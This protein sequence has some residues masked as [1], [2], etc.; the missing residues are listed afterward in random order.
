MRSNWILKMAGVVI[1]PALMAPA[2]WAQK[3]TGDWPL[4]RHDLGGTGYSPLKQINAENA[5]SLKQAW[6]F[7]LSERGGLEVTPIAVKGVMYLP[8]ANKVFA[9]DA[10]TGKEIWHYDVTQPSTRGVAYWPGDKTNPPRIIFTTFGRKMIALDAASGKIVPAFG[11]EGIVDMTVGYNG[12]PTIYKNIVLVGA[13]V[14]E[15]P[16]GPAGDSRAFDA[17]TG[18]QLWD[19][20][21]V[22]EPGETG[23]ETWL[24]DGWK[25]RSGTNVWG[26]YMTV[27][28]KTNTVFMPIGGP[29]P[30]YYGG[31]RP[32]DNLFGNSIVAVDADSGKLKW[33]FQTIHHDLWDQDLPPGP[34]FVDI[35]QNGKTIPALVA[36]GKTSLMFILNRDT[37]KPVFGVEERPVSKGD[38][39]GEWYSP[40]EPFPLKPP[41]LARMSYKP[42]DM[43]TAEYTTPEHVKACQDLL[44][45]SGGSF[46]NAGPFTGWP[47]HEDGTPPKTAI[48]FPGGTGGVNWGGVATDPASHYIYVQTHDMSLIG[49]L[50][51][52][53]PGLVYGR[54]NDG[55]PQLYDRGSVDGPGPYFSF[56]VNMKDAEGH[57]LGVWPCQKPPWGRL[58]AIDANTGDIAWQSVIGITEGLPE[59]KQNTGGGGSAGPIATAGG[60]IFIGA[61]PDDRFRAIDS[62]TG[63]QLWVTKLEKTANADP[64]TYEGKDGKQYVAIVAGDTVYTYTLP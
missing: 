26:W 35:K 60:L 5:S 47:Y 61:T 57:S 39:P 51:K 3:A 12:V 53:K 6:S 46:Y 4:Y 29:S 34:G 9:L 21:S 27:D 15:M 52:R 43:V 42:E 55:S 48:Q 2:G 38:V 58:Y 63:K 16:T 50:E 45:K 22:P 13:S 32:G 40:T 31:D 28:A 30:N 19:F 11:K 8:G 17:L 14:G 44:A 23:H 59:G 54:G 37:G 33:Y 64:M 56:S 7:Q 20:H 25:G 24:N 62:K 10:A 18:A 49:W 1:L 36:V 41:P